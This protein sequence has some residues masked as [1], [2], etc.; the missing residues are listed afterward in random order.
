MKFNI[1]TSSMLCLL[2]AG[3]LAWQANA[4]GTWIQKANIAGAAR[5]AASGFSIDNYG[6]ITSG[7][8]NSNN[9]LTDLWQYD[10]FT[11]SWTQKAN[12]PGTS[13]SSA[14]AFSIGTKGYL[15]LGANN[16]NNFLND[17]WE[18]NSVT[19]TWTQL[20]NFPGAARY[21]AMGISSNGLGYVGMGW[22]GTNYYNDFWEYN[23][24]TDTWTAKA[25]YP[26]MG[27]VECG[28][29]VIRDSIY[30]GSG[31][32]PCGTS[33]SDF[34]KYDPTSDTWAARANI[35]GTTKQNPVCFTLCDTLGFFGLG[36]NCGPPYVLDLN[37]YS[38]ATDT[39]TAAATFPGMG[40]DNPLWFAIANKCYCGTGLNGI[41]LNDFWEYS[42]TGSCDLTG[43][44]ENKTSLNIFSVYPN[45]SLDGRFMLYED[46]KKEEGE[47]RVYNM[48][49][50]KLFYC[51][52]R[53]L[54]SNVIDLS[55][56]GNGIYLIEVR[57]RAKQYFKKIILQKD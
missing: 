10:P 26:G 9:D 22:T 25:N 24:A 23:P 37:R 34:W 21:G 45:P 33:F 52:I 27:R 41:K 18:Y 49:G 57:I 55:Q 28:A 51:A 50:E 54:K 5:W 47:I 13:R 46:I 44:N 15:M 14:T 4:Q 16:S 31:S 19:D 6:Y 2:L 38:P 11:D 17:V 12:F 8:D 56:S 1:R 43:V 39:W 53:K 40:R 32:N 42:I 36:D 20:T 30:A 7:Q 3:S 29:F 35:P 48:F